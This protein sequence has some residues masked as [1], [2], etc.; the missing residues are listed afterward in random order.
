MARIDFEQRA[1]AVEIDAHAFLEINFGLAGDDAGE[2]KDHIGAA[3]DRGACR[4]FIGNIGGRRLD[5]AVE[6]GRLLR[7]DDIDQGEPLDRLAV[8]RAI[9]DQTR[10]E[11]AP[12]HS[13]G[14]GNQNVHF[15][16]PPQSL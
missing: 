10:S 5:L 11:L 12:D 7:R 2:M 16:F 9:A 13:G 4:F 14:A 3:G 1:R 8:E 15:C 6:P